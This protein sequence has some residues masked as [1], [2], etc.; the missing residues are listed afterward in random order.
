VEPINLDELKRF[1]GVPVKILIHDEQ[2]KDQA[3]VVNKIVKKV[4]LCPDGTH[5]RFYFDNYYFLAVPLACEVSQSEE[6]WSAF[7]SVG[8]LHYT[9]EK[10][11]VL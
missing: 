7:D 1:V 6:Q 9:I 4:Q 5:L 8:G 3:P 11:Q 2:S 10:A